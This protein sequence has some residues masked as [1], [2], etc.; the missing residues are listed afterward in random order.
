MEIVPCPLAQTARP[1]PG[2]AR[3]GGS[4]GELSL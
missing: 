3:N 2:P 1:Q 4:D